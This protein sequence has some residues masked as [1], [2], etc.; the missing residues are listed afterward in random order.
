MAGKSKQPKPRRPSRI[1][2]EDRNPT[3]SVRVPQSVKDEFYELAKK[4]GKDINDF[5]QDLIENLI[6]VT[7]KE[8]QKIYHDG[9]YAA[10]LVYCISYK[11]SECGK[12]IIINT[13]EAK[14]AIKQLVIESEWAK[15]NCPEALEQTP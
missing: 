13:P 10:T 6:K 1:G 4:S 3:L 5:F 2:Y 12:I 7:E 11:C 8:K 9:Y 14:K 15:D